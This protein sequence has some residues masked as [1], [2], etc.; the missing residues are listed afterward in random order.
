MHTCGLKWLNMIIIIYYSTGAALPTLNNDINNVHKPL[1]YV[2]VLYDGI[3]DT[4]VTCSAVHRKRLV[5]KLN[6]NSQWSGRLSELKSACRVSL[7]AGRLAGYPVDGILKDNL[8][9]DKRV[10]TKAIKAAKRDHKVVKANRLRDSLRNHNAK[11]FWGVVNNNKNSRLQTDIQCLNAESFVIGFKE[12]FVDSVNKATTISEY[13]N[14]SWSD[15]PV[16]EFS[17]SVKD[18]KKAL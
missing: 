2:N 3:V 11:K 16:V 17:V 14:I 7:N 5:K 18:V 1:E 10:Y 6:N 9:T 12:N 15:V 4:L 13:L 8:I